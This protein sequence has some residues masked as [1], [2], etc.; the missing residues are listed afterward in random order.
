MKKLFVLFVTVLVLLPI[1]VRAEEEVFDRVMK[2]KTVKCGYFVWPPYIDKDPNT[3]KF[4]GVNYDIMEA[5]ARN[6]GWKLNW[7]TEIGVGDVV[8]ALNTNKADIMCASLWPS[9]ARTAGMTFSSASFY[10]VVYAY[11]RSD[12]KRFDGDLEKANNKNIKVAGVDGDVTAELGLEKL[13]NAVPQFLPQTASGSE[14]LMYVVTKKADIVLIDEGLVN[15]FSKT[16][17]GKLRKVSGIGPVRV[18]GEHIAVKKGE[19]HLRDMINMSLLQ[20]TNDGTLE[21]IA[22][23]YSKKYNSVFI[24]P[25]KGYSNHV[26]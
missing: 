15:D 14:A 22:Q 3:G 19:Y 25:A 12:D 20:L 13:P 1:T 26:F 23:K 16:N 5:I 4:S 24:A 9:P 17:P 11:V 8:T 6:L 10:D 18:F 2:T 7:A 21:K